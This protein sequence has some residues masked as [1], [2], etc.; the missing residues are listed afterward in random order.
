MK[1]Y[2]STTTEQ[3]LV[4]VNDI[5]AQDA[6]II[7]LPNITVYNSNTPDSFYETIRNLN[8]NHLIITK[9]KFNNLL[10]LGDNIF[11]MFDRIFIDEASGLSPIQLSSMEDSIK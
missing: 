1:Q 7:D 11:S 8:K 6:F 4:I 9:T 10:T 2:L 5:E 3:I